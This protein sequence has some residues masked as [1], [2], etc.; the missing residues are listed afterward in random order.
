MK[1]ILLVN[2]CLLLFVAQAYS[3]SITVTGK[4]TA[5]SDGA[6]LPGVN[7]TAKGTNTGTQTNG[8]GNFKLEVTGNARSLVFS[9]IGYKSKEVVIGSGAINVTL[10]EDQ[11]SLSEVIVTGYTTQN[12][13]EVTGS[14][15]TVSGEQVAQVPIASFDQA[16]QGRV[17]GVLIQANSGQPGAAA[18]VIIRGRGSILGSTDPLYLVDG[19]E[20]SAANFST[21]NPNDFASFSLLKDAASTSQYGSRGANGV[22]VIT[23]KQG[24][25]G[26]PQ[27]R[28]DFQYGRSKAPANKLKVMNT[29]QKL[30]YELANGNPN[31]WSDE[32]IAGFRLIDTDWED[33]FF[34]KGTT[35]SH[36]LSVSG[37][38]EK[39]KY[40]ISGGAFDQDGIV[41]TTGLKRYTGRANVSSGAKN[42]DFGLTSSFGYSKYTGTSEANTSIASP[43]NAIRWTNPYLAP[44]NADGTYSQ[45]PTGQP[46]PLPELLEN[47]NLRGQLKIIGTVYGVYRFPFAPGLYA[48]VNAG[49][50]Y[51]TNETNTFTDPSTYSGSLQTGQKGALA[52]AYSKFVRYTLT[53]SIGYSKKFGTD[54]TLSA[55]LFNELVKGNGTNFGFTGYG[56]GGAFENESGITP[57]TST[58]G[59]IP[60]VNGNGSENSL[61][62]YF[63]NATYSYKDRYYVQ[64]S[65]RRDGSSRFGANKRYANFGSVGLS[66]IVSNESFFAP[67]KDVLNDLKFKV[68][69]GSAGNQTLSSD[70]ASRNLFSRA[71]YNGGS[72]LLESTLP[73]PD[74]QWERRTTLNVG[75]EFT[76]LKGRIGGT[77]EYYNAVTGDLFLNR[78]LSRTTGYQSIVTNVAELRNRGIEASINADVLKFKDFTWNLFANFTYNQNKVTKLYDG[79]NQ[80][81]QDDGT[82]LRPGELTNSQFLV[83]YV[84][85]NPDNG[86]SIYL[87]KDGKQTED[88]SADDR[89]LVGSAEIPYFGGF[90][91]TINFKGIELNA[92]FSYVWGNKIY[93]NDRTNI[94]NPDYLFDNISVDLLREWRAP[95]QSTDIPRPDQTI[96]TTTT[97]FLEDGKFLRLRNVTLSYDLPK[98]WVS[99]IRLKS[100]RVFM[101][102]Q[103]LITWTKF[104]GFDPEV[105]ANSSLIGAQYPAL[106]TVTA[107]LSVGF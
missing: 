94:E 97:R 6:P 9:N 8:Q 78:Q 106:R 61:L 17:P 30:D 89:V 22:I 53:S 25:V 60:L 84:G 19:I 1:K 75:L 18:N 102:G 62:S 20:I 32:D 2:L 38:S 44:Y 34:K 56:L 52:R 103:N 33:V 58:N 10:E 74:L 99:N 55:A 79:Q 76:A 12:R 3:Q 26:A 39:T 77:V 21:L 40:L 45:N 37:G 83:R 35:R 66:W 5:Q 80:I 69:Y 49:T 88:F 96:Q 24:Q 46:N 98:S 71:L 81:V 72:G 65:A 41:P 59:F 7:V 64:A 51:T 13:R 54:H 57:G 42:F 63:A 31:E 104:R 47:K 43:L 50:D 100:V 16:L 15:A 14:V 85:V 91:T 48:K 36:N 101:Q 82:V 4:V 107:G 70:F 87:D 68:S 28:Y 90:G 67:V 86:N 95:G 73:A 93:N 105:A 27:F 29:A 11:K 23:T 92:L